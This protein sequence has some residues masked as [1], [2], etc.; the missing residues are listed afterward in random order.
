MAETY[1]NVVADARIALPGIPIYTDAV[2]LRLTNKIHKELVE[3][4][5]LV[6][7]TADLTLTT[8]DR[9]YDLNEGHVAIWSAEYRTSATAKPFPVYETSVDE[10]DT[11]DAG[12]RDG[13]SGRPELYYQYAKSTGAAVVG[14]DR[15]PPTASSGGYPTVRLYVSLYTAL[16]SGDSIPATV[17]TSNVYVFGL[18]SEWARLRDPEKFEYFNAE[19]EKEKNKLAVYADRRQRRNHSR[20]IPFLRLGSRAY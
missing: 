4:F 9:E 8:T 12:W 19:F 17:R 15:L 11:D 7:T 6:V 10:L 18:C 16:A 2:T 5:R 13:R 1:Q 14:F 20:Q 3:E